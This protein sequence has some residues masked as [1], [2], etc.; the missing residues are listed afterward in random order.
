M[1]SSA[2]PFH[3]QVQKSAELAGQFDDLMR[4]SPALGRMLLDNWNTYYEFSKANG[5]PRKKKPG[6]PK[7]DHDRA[8][9]AAAKALAG[10]GWIG[11]PQLAKLAG[12]SDKSKLKAAMRA[13]PDKFEERTD[14]TN[15]RRFQWRLKEGH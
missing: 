9:Q 14:P 10:G 1:K 3:E 4:H 15:E 12:I 5:E 6:R 8:E 11:T 7:G 2:S 13:K